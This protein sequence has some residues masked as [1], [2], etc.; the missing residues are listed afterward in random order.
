V[1]NE[2]GLVGYGLEK[3]SLGEEVGDK[4]EGIRE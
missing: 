3:S 2:N 1:G 4:V